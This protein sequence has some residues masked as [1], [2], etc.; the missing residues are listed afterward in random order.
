MPKPGPISIIEFIDFLES[1]G[2]KPSSINIHLRTI[3]TMFRY[4]LKMEK[5][6]KIPLIEQLKVKKKE[7]IYITDEEFQKIVN[8][9]WLDNVLNNV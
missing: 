4:W 5:V 7:P 6:N 9:E 2:L 8:L 3:K 1:K